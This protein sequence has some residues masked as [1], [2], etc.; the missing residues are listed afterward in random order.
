MEPEE[1]VENCIEPEKASCTV[2]SNDVDMSSPKQ[3]ETENKINTKENPICEN[4]SNFAVICSFIEQ[5][6]SSLDLHLDIA[7]LKTMLETNDTT[8]EELVELH[9]KLLRKRRKYIQRDKWERALAR[10]ISE[11]S[12]VDAWELERYGYKNVNL[13]I[14]I[15]AF[16]TL[17]EAQFD[18]NAKFK[19]SINAMEASTLRL[20][21]I[22]RD[23]HGN[24]YWYQLDPHSCL[25]VYREEPDDENSWIL[26]AKDKD[27]LAALISNLKSQS[28][29]QLKDSAPV[30]EN[31][32]EN[33]DSN[34][35]ESS[36]NIKE[37][38]REEKSSL[39]KQNHLI[40]VKSENHDELKEP[41]VEHLEELTCYQRS[42]NKCIPKN[43]IKKE[44]CMEPKQSTNLTSESSSSSNNVHFNASNYLSSID[45]EVGDVLNDILDKISSD[46]TPMH[47]S[48]DVEFQDIIDLCNQ[49]VDQVCAN[50][51]LPILPPNSSKPSHEQIPLITPLKSSSPSLPSPLT[52]SLASTC[53]VKPS[54]EE[55]ENLQD[56]EE[57]KKESEDEEL[58][59]TISGSAK[60]R[61]RKPKRGLRKRA[62]QNQNDRNLD[63][64]SES[65]SQSATDVKPTKVDTKT[66][67]RRGGGRGRGRKVSIPEL[68]I[69]EKAARSPS[70]Q[71]VKRQSR[72]IQALQ[73]KKNAELAEKVKREQQLLEEMAKKMQAN[74]VK[75]QENSCDSFSRDSKKDNVYQTEDSSSDSDHVTTKKRTKKRKRGKGGKAGKAGCPW[76]SASSS[77]SSEEE[78][79]EEIEEEDDEVLQF[80]DNEDEFACEEPDPDAEP[81]ILKRARTAKKIKEKIT[82]QGSSSEAEEEINDDTPC[83]RC[84]KYDHPEWI[85]L[86]DKCDTGFH[87]A[88]LKPPLMLIPDG[89]WFCPPCENLFLLEK[90]E[91]KFEALAK[92][93]EKRELEEMRKQR[94]KQ[95][96]ASLDAL[97]KPKPK[98]E[99]CKKPTNEERVKERARKYSRR[100]SDDDNSED[101]RSDNDDSEDDSDESDYLMLRSSRSRKKISYQFTEYDEMINSAIL[102]EGY[103][104]PPDAP[105]GQSRGKDM[106]TIEHALKQQ[107]AEER[108]EELKITTQPEIKPEN[109]VPAEVEQNEPPEAEE[110]EEVDMDSDFEPEKPRKLSRHLKKRRL[111]DLEPPS[112]DDDSDESF[113]GGSDTE[114]EDLSEESLEEIDDE[115]EESNESWKD[116]RRSKKSKGRK[117][118]R[119]KSGKKKGYRRDDFVVDSDDSDYGAGKR[120]RTRAAAKKRVSYKEFTSDE[121]EEEEYEW[122]SKK[123][124]KRKLSGSE[125]S[126][127]E[128]EDEDDDDITTKKKKKKNAISDD[129]EDEEE[130]EME[131]EEEEEEENDED[132]R[133]DS[134]R[135]EKLAKSKKDKKA[136]S[137]PISDEE[138]DDEP[139][140]DDEEEFEEKKSKK[141]HDVKESPKKSKS[142]KGKPA[143]KFEM[144]GK[145]RLSKARMMSL[146]ENSD[147]SQETKTIPDAE[148]G[149][150]QSDSFGPN[151]NL[152]A[153]KPQSIPTAEVI[154]V[155]VTEVNKALPL[156]LVGPQKD[157]G[158]HQHNIPRDG[159]VHPMSGNVPPDHRQES[160]GPNVSQR[161]APNL[162]LPPGKPSALSQLTA[163]ASKG[164]GHPG[165][166]ATHIHSVN[167][168]SVDY[169]SSHHVQQIPP[170]PASSRPHGS[171]KEESDYSI[172]SL[173]AYGNNQRQMKSMSIE[174]YCPPTSSPS[175]L[176]HLES[177]Q[178]NPQGPPPPQMANMERFPSNFA[179]NSKN[180][181]SR[182]PGPF[183]ESIPPRD[184]PPRQPYPPQSANFPGDP[185]AFYDPQMMR[186]NHGNAGPYPH[187]NAH[188]GNSPYR[189]R[190]GPMHYG[191]NPGPR[192]GPGFYPQP[193]PGFYS[194]PGPMPRNSNRPPH[195]AQNMPPSTRPTGPH[196]LER[197]PPYPGPPHLYPPGHPAS[198]MAA[199]FPPNAF[200]PHPGEFLPN[201]GFMIQNLLHAPLPNQ[202]NPPN[203]ANGLEGAATTGSPSITPNPTHTNSNG[204]PAAT[205]GANQPPPSQPPTN[206]IAQPP[207]ISSP[208]D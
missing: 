84:G 181:D 113:K 73:E 165:G 178:Y 115:T 65:E 192:P 177:S 155:T 22:G 81:I 8:P 148:S 169:P 149:K 42:Q 32:S 52:S 150:V 186:P 198:A 166:P 87:T 24:Q 58:K 104:A 142:P 10:F 156:H 66:R 11:Y 49:L 23:I 96:A 85:L 114:V 63:E 1:A 204:L 15:T 40:E 125:T 95:V 203:R 2:E 48:F 25:R 157:V 59:S 122:K 70:P 16:K 12:N 72:R 185:R 92:A 205:Q 38:P 132:E 13:G 136:K 160:L 137:K 78:E 93:L 138:D 46:S 152:S 139:E 17:L 184:Y 61:G 167:P 50:S 158:E 105:Y 39:L 116:F 31:I 21:P 187:P 36:V 208:S 77:E 120:S 130:E 196:T 146:A 7:K 190:S 56:Q 153:E 123:S 143:K 64:K 79:E 67:G 202:P 129:E 28:L 4:D 35:N 179:P 9:I 175:Q 170:H 20:A 126:D 191:P 161:I 118:M 62:P 103:D 109:P 141:R 18:Y 106:A 53:P 55:S 83:Q 89:D 37:E 133:Y 174:N 43:E 80:D 131:E 110:K 68:E 26:I 159:P 107:E 119:G 100:L 111:N 199:H 194:R 168:N 44:I 97:S 128:W 171:D 163:F 27:D 201:G 176:L 127:E 207:P 154:P 47:K 75:S 193:G 29:D 88:C 45:S 33:E 86:C 94:L 34:L 71:P 90:L 173:D 188:P 91:E 41:N 134:E 124:K 121:E 57:N 82:D 195:L 14:R 102:D 140:E 135:E 164:P 200:Y 30:S 101:D 74:K 162:I 54:L 3:E 108:E 19:S 197:P 144:R 60:K 182:M 183:H 117:V 112:E 180:P 69:I 145:P 6:G 99:I 51:H 151:K 5:F 76:D 189:Q 98:I 172:M 147:D 206:Q